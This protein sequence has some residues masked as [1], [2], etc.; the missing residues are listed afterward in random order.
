MRISPEHWK[1][2]RELYETALAY[3]PPQRAAYLRKNAKDEVVRDEVLRLIAEHASLG[4]SF[5]TP[6]FVDPHLDRTD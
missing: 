4:A 1:R 5:S 6:R 2:V 3:S